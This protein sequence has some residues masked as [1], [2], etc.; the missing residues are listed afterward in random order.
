MTEK[1]LA[2]LNGLPTEDPGPRRTAGGLAKYVQGGTVERIIQKVLPNYA[3]KRARARYGL[4]MGAMVAGYEGASMSKPSLRNWRPVPYDANSLIQFDQQYL[5]DRSRDLERNNA[6]ALGAINTKCTSVIGTGL[7]LHAK[8]D[9]KFLTMDDDAAN[10]WESNAERE[11]KLWYNSIESDAARI[12]SGPSRQQQVYRRRLVD[13]D[14]LSLLKHIRRPGNPYALKEQIVE[15]DRLT[16][17]GWAANSQSRAGGIDKDENGAP[18]T[19]HIMNRYPWQV[20]TNLASLEWIPVPAFGGNTGRRNVLHVFKQERPGQNRGV[21]DLAPV[22]HLLKQLGRFTEAE[23]DAA[24][25]NSYFTV[26]FTS[27]MGGEDD[28]KT[29]MGG[30]QKTYSPSSADDVDLGP[31]LVHM[32]PPGTKPEF[33]DPKRPNAN[34]GAFVEALFQQIG[35]A[36]EIPYEILIKHFT[37]SYSASQGA[38][39]EAWRFFKSE[40]K[41]F[42]GNYLQPLYETFLMEAVSMG[43]LSAPGFFRDPLVRQAYCGTQWH[44]DPRGMIDQVKEISAANLRI[45]MGMTTLEAETAEIT[46]GDWEKNIPQIR[47]ERQILSDLGLM[48]VMTK[49]SIAPKPAGGPQE[50]VPDPSQPPEDPGG[51]GSEGSDALLAIGRTTVMS[52]IKKAIE[53]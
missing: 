7:T 20:G 41:W 14:V 8:I 46:G 51:D 28:F 12:L 43:R 35:V 22:M 11:W 50:G 44:G 33:A 34:F 24:V 38:L 27:D 36:L 40:R 31:G 18:V 13:G 16:N 39:L 17:P 19:Y 47:R 23:V 45:L 37:S 32:A 10:E 2:K 15:G 3:L 4:A 52:E 42:I 1:E 53:D 9:S 30:Q 6:L 21:P 26:F 29:V 49:M 25:I 5:R 48:P